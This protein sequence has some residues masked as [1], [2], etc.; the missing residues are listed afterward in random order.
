MQGITTVVY[1]TKLLQTGPKA[2][3]YQRLM[4]GPKHTFYSLTN[5]I[6]PTLKPIKNTQKISGALRTHA[7]SQLLIYYLVD[8]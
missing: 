1:N 6:V 8:V 4:S 3:R 5:S 2:A 7:S